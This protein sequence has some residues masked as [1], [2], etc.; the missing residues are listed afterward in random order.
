MSFN[1]YF[2]RCSSLDP[3]FHEIEEVLE[4][5]GPAS[6]QEQLMMTELADDVVA[7]FDGTEWGPSSAGL[8]H[9]LGIVGGDLP[10]I[11]VSAKAA[12]INARPGLEELGVYKELIAL[13]AQHGFV[14]FDPQR[15]IVVNAET[16]AF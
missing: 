3:S 7:K 15:G 2:L 6:R 11:R 13:F 10:G 16:F 1:L 14:C 4:Y 9:G 8:A 5:D 12:F